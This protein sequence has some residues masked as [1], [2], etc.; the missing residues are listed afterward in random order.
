MPSASNPPRLSP[1]PKRILAVL[2]T[3][4]MA[5]GLTVGV[6]TAAS[7]HT[8]NVTADCDSLNVQF[9]SYGAN[10]VNFYTFSIDG[11]AVETNKQ[12]GDSYGPV[13]YKVTP[14]V[15]HT[16]KLEI[17]AQH[18]GEDKLGAGALTGTFTPCSTASTCVN[19]LTGLNNFTIVTEGDLTVSRSGAHVEGT[20]AVGGNLIVTESYHVQNNHDGT[21]LPVVE[22]K[23]T[24]LLVNGSITL[25]T[26][27]EAFKVLA[28]ATR[29]GN[30]AAAAS[31]DGSGKF[32]PTADTGRWVKM[33]AAATIAEVKAPGV[34]ATVFPNLFTA[35]R[36][37]SDDI[38]D[39]TATDDA[40]FVT[41]TP[42]G[43]DGQQVTL[44]AGITNVLRLNASQL[45]AVTKLWI[46]GSVKPS[47][48]TP[49]IIDVTGSGAL[50]VTA[51]TLMNIDERYVLW[52]F[53]KATTLNLS[54]SEFVSGSILAPRAQLN[55]LTGGVEGQIA[56][57]S[58]VVTSIGEIHHVAYSPCATPPKVVTVSPVPSAAPPT[59]AADGS[60][61]VPTIAN[62]TWTGGLNG[63]GPG[64]YTLIATPAAGYTLAGAQSSW[65]ITVL[66]KGTGVNCEQSV[67]PDLTIAECHATTGAVTSAYITIPST[68]PHLTYSIGA[69]SY[70][71]G[72]KVPLAPGTHT[73]TVTPAANWT[74]TGPGSYTIVV[75]ALG[76]DKAVE[77]AL[78]EA[79]CSTTTPPTVTSAFITIPSTTPN[80]TYSIGA[81]N[82]T[83]G[84]KVTLA[85]GTH[86]VNVTPD[87][88]WKNTGPSSFT[89]VVG[90]LGCE[91]AVQ[92][93]ITSAVC[94]TATPPTVTSAYI[95]IPSTTPHL[96]Y[97]IGAT[98]Y[99]AGQKVDLAAGT[100]TVTVTTAAGWRNTGPTSFTIVIAALG[101]EKAVAPALTVAECS[102]DTGALVSGFITI[103]STTP[104]LTYSIG[105]T[106][107]A[108][109]QKVNLAAGSYTVNVTA[110]AGWTNTGATSFPIVITPLGCESSEKPD[111]TVA[112]CDVNGAATT[113]YITI[114]TTTPHLT[115]SIGA[116]TYT[117]GQ[118][119]PLTPGS[120]TVTVTAQTGW[121]N[122]GPATFKIS[123]DQF[124]CD[125]AVEPVL[126]AAVCTPLTG[127]MKAY[128]TIPTTTPHL[129]Y[130]Y[131]GTPYAAGAKVELPSGP[132]TITVTAEP[133]WKNTGPAS[134]SDTVDPVDCV[135]VSYVEPDIT[136]EVCDTD[137]GGTTQGSLVFKLDP[138]L[139]YY[140]EGALV[141][142]TTPILLNPGT[143]EI[144]VV[145]SAGH[146]LKNGVDTYYVTIDPAVGCDGVYTIPLDPY[147]DPETCDPLSID[148]E[149][150][151]GSVTVVHVA[152]VQFSIGTKADGS[153]RVAVGTSATVGT[154]AYPYAAGS[155]YVFA[156]STDP[157]I[158]IKPGH[159]LWGPLT[160]GVPN[161]VCLPTRG[162]L[163]ADAQPKDAVCDVFGSPRG[164]ITILPT[165]GVTYAFQGGAKITTTAT[166]V[167]PGTYTIVATA[168]DG[169]STLTASK[170]VVTIG[171]SLA[172]CDL[173]T[174][175]F[176]GQN[177]TGFIL[178]ALV[179]LQAG[180][181]LIA[182]R[183]IRR[184]REARHLA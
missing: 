129:I 93:A 2:A 96:T 61:I 54:T 98:T 73:V 3:L 162:L 110:D 36:T 108:A 158:T 166:S 155:Y 30:V 170:W 35:L 128:V 97:S 19:P 71:A 139:A 143:Y 179:L 57:K 46:P 58:M 59:C 123:V 79:Q 26:G 95:T 144:T 148:G 100:H 114:P 13:E 134:F 69:T 91:K 11:V 149:K 41:M 112:D 146:Y 109:G 44:T 45:S 1:V 81:T 177:P 7:A 175:A 78:T 182:V 145:P 32:F 34:F 75:A 63:A 119:V 72:Q 154:V 151:N 43:G 10:T 173:T 163:E 113:A 9:K 6:S 105:A 127:P 87:A 62:I 56:A 49:F 14:N 52:N 135:D 86:V 132:Y 111:L 77:P 27:N 18:N 83:A 74:N 84:Q 176:T 51:P 115:Y 152:G 124:D 125:K 22:G 116:T 174:L 106:T 126:T 150:V 64:T 121:K 23:S 29:V 50:T 28:G 159:S 180:L 53:A 137:L 184:R 157:A 17:N 16:W 94:T 68:T 102:V 168:D 25:N 160:V 103:P 42:N 66:P 171:T 90:A 89:I 183:Y 80:L 120:Y 15:S 5:V 107:Y 37:Q 153:D 101:C 156:V 133:G 141:T 33:A 178:G 138:E 48:T 130:S 169:I 99:A 21:A 147:A 8:P 172:V 181:A 65:T 76:C 39:Y 88:G 20:A 165:P 164:A 136:P 12:F 40:V 118:Q 140:L 167:A 70:A 122:T 47:A 117:A 31:T 67:K 55:L 92:P 85:A 82:Y 60:L 131:G 142:S 4:L 161:P 104:H 24:G 38:G